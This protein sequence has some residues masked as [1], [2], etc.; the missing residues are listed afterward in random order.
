LE[1]DEAAR[2]RGEIVRWCYSAVVATVSIAFALL[3]PERPAPWLT[4]MP[5]MVYALLAGTGRVTAWFARR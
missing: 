2:A 5:G 3:L 1:P 4:G